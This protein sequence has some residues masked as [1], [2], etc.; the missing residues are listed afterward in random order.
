M[1]VAG[2]QQPP[3]DELYIRPKK[4]NDLMKV[5]QGMR[6]TVYI[7]GCT[8]LGKTALVMDY[9]ARRRYEYYSMTERS[10]GEIPPPRVGGQERIV[11]V[12]D[13]H[14]LQSTQDREEAYTHLKRLACHSTVWLILISRAALP[15]WLRPLHIESIFVTIGERELCFSSKEEAAYIAQWEL[16]LMPDTHHRLRELGHGHPLFLRIALMYLRQQALSS[17]CQS[18]SER[19][20]EEMT[21]IETVRRDWW[22]YLDVHVFDQWDV[23]LLEFLMD[24][25]VVERFDLDMARAI[26]RKND[27]GRLIQQALETGSFMRECLQDSSMVWELMKPMRLAMRR[28]L[29][30][31]CTL[32][33]IDGLYRS[34]G[35]SYEMQA[36]LPE[37]LAMY[38]KC[39]YEEGIS[40]LLIDNARKPA[41]SGHY[42]ALRRY[43]LALSEEAVR[44]SPELMAGMSLLQ[45]ILMNDEESERW[46]QVLTDYVNKQTGSSRKA[47]QARLLYLEIALPQRGTGNTIE[48][49]RHA[50]TLLTQ[51]KVML[52]EMSLTNNQ[53]TLMHGGKDFCE[54]SRHDRE[55]SITLRPFLETLLGGF[56]KGV[57]NLALA[58]SLFEKGA[59]N[60]EVSELAQKGRMQA[61]S[62]GKSEVVFVAVGLLAQ[63]SALNNRLQ[64]ALENL[65]SFRGSVEKD[66]PH[67]LAGIDALRVR[68]LLYQGSNSETDEWLANAPDEE[69]EFCTLERYRY[70]TKARVY[71][72]AGRVEK[73]QALLE[74]LLLYAEKRQ[75]TFLQLEASVLSAIVQN[76]VEDEKWADTLQAVISRAEDYHFVR[77]LTKE[78]AVLWRLLRLRE[79]TWR[80]NGFRKQVMKE[81]ERVARFYPSY[82]SYK[83]EGRILLGDKALMV[84]RLQAEGLNVEQIAQRM[85]LSIAGVKYYN[86]ETYKK[87]GVSN[88]AAAIHEAR[89]RRLL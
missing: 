78:G 70:I 64:D 66:A 67:L 21:A 46:V 54:W 45:S 13:L 85:N 38:E 30:K 42:W 16:T 81:C 65:S 11:V 76:R 10:L 74:R 59:D 33:H 86:Q 6:Q 39:H 61:Q 5:A 71:L 44:K 80:D 68:L 24:I 72:A 41:G 36:L 17:A 32:T 14:A 47:A 20:K 27:V 48:L 43:Y 73:A 8:G 77:V 88:K 50:W 19:R 26:T 7:H 29:I 75:R 56:S 37:A 40:R 62:G 12:D 3:G 28:R 4:A 18:S 87:L 35:E 31:H 53:P 83:N 34:A 2:S 49:L 15:A 9:L 55:L 82:L 84:L 52:P 22:D 63:L 89:N 79:F 58:E 60:Y 23:E 25:S 1:Q 57:V 51:R 69:A